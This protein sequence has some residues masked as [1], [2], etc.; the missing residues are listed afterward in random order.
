MDDEEPVLK[1]VDA[2][3]TVLLV[4][5]VAT[6]FADAL[7]PVRWVTPTRVT[8]VAQ[9]LGLA[10]AAAFGA[11]ALAAGALLFELRFV[12][13]CV[14]GKLARQRRSTSA[15][16]GFLDAIGDS[17]VVALMLVALAARL[18]ADGDLRAA[19]AVGLPAAYLAHVLVTVARQDVATRARAAL[20]LTADAL[21][22]G[23][24]R[25]MAQRRLRALPSRVDAEHGLLLVGPVASWITGEPRYV[26]ALAVVGLVY[27]AY[28][29]VHIGA[30]G[31]K[32]ARAIDDAAGGG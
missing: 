20:P 23:Y 27:F 13:D 29:V 9:L 16:G 31:W 14:D 10:A 25:W 17:I 1:Q 30:G 12:L 7:V 22:D 8:V 26:A 28:Q 11:G 3:T 5:P 18:H 24:R 19:V 21:P 2:W 15:A 6:R 32:L 4:D